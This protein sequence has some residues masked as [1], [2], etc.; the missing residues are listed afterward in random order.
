MST[1]IHPPL[2]ASADAAP[3]DRYCARMMEAAPTDLGIPA[4]FCLCAQFAQVRADELLQL[5]DALKSLPG[6]I[7][8]ALRAAINRRLIAH[9]MTALLPSK[10]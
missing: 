2:D 3:H 4:D 1:E 10:R 5:T 8:D 7:P 9:L 6:D